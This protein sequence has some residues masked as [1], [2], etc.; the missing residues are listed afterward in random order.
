MPAD[1]PVVTPVDE[2]IVATAVVLLLQVPDGVASLSAV[3]RPWHT[4]RVP[5]IAAGNGL[6]VNADV[7]I[8]PVDGNV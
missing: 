7:V 2:L 4:V 6:T 5:A 3:V 1:I 8:Q